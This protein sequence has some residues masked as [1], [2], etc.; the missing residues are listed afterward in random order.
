MNLMERIKNML[1]TPKKEWEV[2]ADENEDHV[3]VLT[4]YLLILA[5]IPAVAAFIGWGLVGYK[6]Y[7]VR[8][9][10]VGLGLRYAI[11]QFVTVIAGAYLTAWVFNE[12]APKYGGEKNFGK[13]FQLSA[14][15]YTAVCIGGLFYILPSLSMLASLAGL[16]ALYLL[17]I[18]LKPM[19]KVPDDKV[20][21]YFLISLI[22]MIAIS[23]VLSLILGAVIGIRSYG[24]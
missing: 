15:C 18:G 21:S 23:V 19:M 8:V 13:A 10:G 11:I 20:S 4:S 5:V 17:Y 22:G 12:L 1:L 24:F 16:Y 6:V 2:V 9:A 14:Y 3:K 7:I